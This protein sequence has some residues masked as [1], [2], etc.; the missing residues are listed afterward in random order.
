MED[1]SLKL[2]VEKILQNKM[3]SKAKFIPGFVVSWLKRILHQDEL[4]VFLMEKGHDTGVDFFDDCLEFL[5]IKLDIK[6]LENL[7]HDGRNFTFVSNHPLGGIDGVALGAVIGHQYDYKIKYLVNDLLMNI[8][9]L[10]PLFV[11]INKTGSQ[12]KKFPAIVEG[13][14]K[15][16]SNVLMFPAGL[17][18]RKQ[19]GVI[20]DLQW[21]KTFVVKSIETQR[22]VIPIHFEGQNSN[23]F[24]NLANICKM[25][26][27][28][29]NLAML[30]LADEMMKNRHKT[31]KVTFG[32][33]IP[34][35]TFDKSRTPA[36]WAEYVKDIV[37]KL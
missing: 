37:Y 14:F 21:K 8:K 22:D 27:I 10:A 28:K 23:F 17:C 16:D 29:F 24:Y 35:Q 12:S 3:G 11:G 1:E 20:R 4:N 19:N 26:G 33:P 32:K 9:P 18:S 31:Y 7:P 13:V 25:L 6:G 36:Q 15:S 30:F 34:Y 5:D 2:D